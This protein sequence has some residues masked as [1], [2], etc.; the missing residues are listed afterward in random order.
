MIYYPLSVLMMAGI[1]DILVITTPHEQHLFSQLLGDGGQWGIDLSFAEQ[2]K[3]EGLAQPLL[4]GRECIAGDQ[5][6]LNTGENLFYGQGLPNESVRPPPN[7]AGPPV[8]GNHW[9]NS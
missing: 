7:P 1:R 9:S 6:H 8:C 5:C 4:I 3:P 2:P